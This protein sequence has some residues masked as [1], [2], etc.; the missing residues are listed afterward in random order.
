MRMLV[1]IG[2]LAALLL[3]GGFLSFAFM[4]IEVPQKDVSIE[5]PVPQT[6]QPQSQAPALTLDST[7]A[8]TPAGLAADSAAPATTTTGGAE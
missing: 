3:L 7:P 6:A 2:V 1:T 5:L 4:D 8:A